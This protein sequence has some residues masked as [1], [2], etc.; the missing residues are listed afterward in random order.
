MV[1]TCT[2]EDDEDSEEYFWRQKEQPECKSPVIYDKRTY[3][4]YS[5]YSML[6]H[7]RADDSDFDSSIQD[8]P[9]KTEC[10]EFSSITQ[11]ASKSE[12]KDSVSSFQIPEKPTDDQSEVD[13]QAALSKQRQK[14]KKKKSQK[15][16]KINYGINLI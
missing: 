6:L 7:S 13:E 14:Q 12:I 10:S 16:Q 9:A 1:S 3:M 2:E 8:T 5:Q 4:R 11:S 15:V